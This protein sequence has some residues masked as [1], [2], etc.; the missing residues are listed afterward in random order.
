MIGIQEERA[1]THISSVDVNFSSKKALQQ[2]INTTLTRWNCIR[3]P[4]EWNEHIYYDDAVAKKTDR[5]ANDLYLFE[6]ETTG[7]RVYSVSMSVFGRYR[8]GGNLID[9]FEQLMDSLEVQLLHPD[10]EFT[11]MSDCHELQANLNTSPLPIRGALAESVMYD[12]ALDEDEELEE[13][14]FEE[15]ELEE[16]DF[17]EEDD[18]E[19]PLKDMNDVQIE[20]YIESLGRCARDECEEWA[21][22]YEGGPILRYS[23]VNFNNSSVT[24]QIVEKIT[25]SGATFNN[26]TL[27][28]CRFSR[29][30]F[31]ECD[32]TDVK[33][34][35][36]KFKRCNFYDCE[37]PDYVKLDDNC[38]VS[39]M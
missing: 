31:Y 14:D 12:E 23:Y 25:I 22:N 33:I 24:D 19:I 30:D 2:L 32:F 7:P 28:N 20:E 6:V 3:G 8:R 35:N 9:F 26:T 4:I 16:E 29:V 11:E 36:T 39:N 27:K 13:E 17:D 1:S 21:L 34:K 15:E 5:L 10:Q 38:L 18:L 37:L